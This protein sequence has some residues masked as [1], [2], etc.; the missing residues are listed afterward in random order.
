MA[1]IGGFM[2]FAG[3]VILGSA[4]LALFNYLDVSMLLNEKYLPI[5]AIIML[6]TGLFDTIAAIVMARW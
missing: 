3:I 4:V 6:V 1:I 5:L 2:V